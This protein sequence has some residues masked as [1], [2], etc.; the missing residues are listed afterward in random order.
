DERLR[1]DAR[2]QHGGALL[3]SRGV[4]RMRNGASQRPARA[5]SACGLSA[6]EVWQYRPSV[7]AHLA[8][9]RRAVHALK[10]VR[11]G[12]AD[13]C[14]P[15]A[16]VHAATSAGYARCDCWP[17]RDRCETSAPM[18]WLCPWHALLSL[19]FLLKT[20]LRMQKE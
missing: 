18:P 5:C 19:K 3:P 13:R 10:G 1:P 7:H 12:C 11:R 6:S 20:K 9:V 17:G 4:V 2:L 8:A 14:A 16:V 15:L